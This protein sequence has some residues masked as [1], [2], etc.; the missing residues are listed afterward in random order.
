MIRATKAT[1][2]EKKIFSKKPMKNNPKLILIKIIINKAP[3]YLR[4]SQSNSTSSSAMRRNESAHKNGAITTNVIRAA[5]VF[6]NRVSATKGA[7]NLADNKMTAVI[8]TVWRIICT[9]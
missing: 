1:N 9:I 5:N 6:P 7:T 4:S 8:I 2:G 3:R